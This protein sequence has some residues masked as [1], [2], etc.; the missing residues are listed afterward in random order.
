MHKHRLISRPLA[1]SP[2]KARR[3]RAEI[4]AEQVPATATIKREY[5]NCGKCPTQHGP[6]WYAYWSAKGKT[7]KRYIGSDAALADFLTL[8]TEHQA[9]AS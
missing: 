2:K 8:R 6:Y 3:S 4:L 7:R 9:E 5:V 1:R